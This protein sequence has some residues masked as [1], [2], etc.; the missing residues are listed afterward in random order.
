MD[1][2]ERRKNSE[3]ATTPPSSLLLSCAPPCP[4][5]QT[6]TTNRSPRRRANLQISSSDPLAAGPTAPAA[7]CPPLRCAP[8]SRP[9]PSPSCRWR[10]TCPRFPPLPSQPSRWCLG[11]ATPVSFFDAR[12]V[13]KDSPPLRTISSMSFLA[14]DMVRYSPAGGRSARK[15][16]QAF[17]SRR[18]CARRCRLLSS[19]KRSAKPWTTFSPRSAGAFPAGGPAEPRAGPLLAHTASLRYMG[20]CLSGQPT[21]TPGSAAAFAQGVPGSLVLRRWG[22]RGGPLGPGE[23]D[24]AG[25]QAHPC[26]FQSRDEGHNADDDEHNGF[27]KDRKDQKQF[28]KKKMDGTEEVE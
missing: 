13:R 22:R 15:R 18:S 1:I 2:G 20:P 19:R 8:A 11:R 6:T 27:R 4:A 9:G 23:E 7:P 14:Y 17:Q 3:R 5:A 26:R 25:R 24:P 12:V 16:F 28:S 21:P 10:P